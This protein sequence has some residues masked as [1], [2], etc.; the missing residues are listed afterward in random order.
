MQIPSWSEHA[1]A[2]ISHPTT[3]THADVCTNP[4]QPL[5]HMH[6]CVQIPL[7]HYH[8]CT[9]VYR[10]HSTTITHAVCVQIPT[11]H[12]HTCRCV[13]KSHSTTISHADMCID[14]NQS[15][16]YIIMHTC[17]QVQIPTNH[18]HTCRH[19]YRSHMQTCVQI[20]VNYYH[21][22]RHV[23]R[24]QPTTITHADMCTDP[25]QP[26]S[27]MQTCVQIPTNHYHTC[28]HVY[29][30]QPT[31]I[32]HADMGTDPSQPLLHMQTWVQIPVN[33]YHTC[34]PITK[35]THMNTLHLFLLIEFSDTVS[36]YIQHMIIMEISK[37]PT[38]W[39]KALNKQNLTH[40]MYIKMKKVI[41]NFT[42]ANTKCTPQQGFKHN[43]ATHT[44]TR[45]HARTHTHTLYKLTGVK[46]ILT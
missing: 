8:T 44:H 38:L 18:Y 5:S 9:C 28:W 20:P 7:N 26:L 4:T 41:W 1:H 22:C 24:S 6:M 3:V 29:R 40:V 15:L 46:D 13:C 45:M 43:C 35:P 10:S 37:A 31:T 21:T 14:P 30:S 25:N 12:Y 2:Y 23:Y 33:H 27:H 39:L 36:I 17:I 32:T 11:N 34:R 19:V 42:K 16:S